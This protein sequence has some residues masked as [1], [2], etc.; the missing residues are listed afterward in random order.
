MSR[1]ESGLLT[2]ND[3]PAVTVE[4]PAGASCWVLVCDHAGFRVPERLGGLGLEPAALKSHVA[5][6][7]GAAAV[8]TGMS[9][10]LD[11][12]LVLQAY[13]RLVIDCNRPTDSAASIVGRSENTEIPGNQGLTPDE[14]EARVD[15]VFRPYHEAIDG[16]LDG[17][18]RSGQASGL[19]AIHSFTPTYHGRERPWE[20]GIIHNHDR[21]LGTAL[22]DGLR[23]EGLEVGD[24]QPYS[25]ADEVDYTITRHGHPRRI[26]HTMIEIRD[27]LLGGDAE[28]A[29]WAARLATL[30]DAVT[31]DMISGGGAVAA[32]R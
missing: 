3:P 17:R 28:R 32:R 21:E 16:L 5:G 15:A 11:A 26:P 14:A 23:A 20:I 12:P 19:V 2:D 6:D 1:G 31:G 29:A 9:E 13:T 8:A 25:P 4:R 22:I 27:D 10:R 30:L 24:N 7:N 18:T